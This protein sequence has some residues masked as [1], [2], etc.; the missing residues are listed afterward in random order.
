MLEKEAIEKGIDIE[1]LKE[2]QKKLSKLVVFEDKIDF[3]LAN[4]FAGIDIEFLKT[5]EILVSIVIIG[6]NMQ[7][8]EERYSIDKI[9]FPYLIGFRAYRELMTILETFRKLEEGFD[10]VFIKANG[11]SHARNCGLATH[12]GILLN[13]PVI[14]ITE[15]IDESAKT[16]GEYIYT[17]NKKTAKKITTKEGSKPFYVDVGNLIS[18]DS[19]LMLTKK[20]IIPPHKLPE[21]LILA[22]KSTNK[23]RKILFLEE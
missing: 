18:L 19:A 17:G 21:P 2:E 7:I 3:S 10:V 4:R 16:K 6:E 15:H 22:K 20:M 1:K 12:L 9:K 11:L 23:T 14:G 8:I 5:K 13:K